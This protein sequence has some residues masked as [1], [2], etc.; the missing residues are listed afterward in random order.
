M[1]AFNFPQVIEIPRGEQSKSDSTQIDKAINYI[2]GLEK[3][4]FKEFVLRDLF[5]KGN[6]LKEDNYPSKASF[7]FKI[8]IHFYPDSFEVHR[9]LV[10]FFDQ[11]GAFEEAEKLL[12]VSISKNFEQ[13]SSFMLI[14]A[15]LY[16]ATGKP[17]LSVIEYEKVLRIDKGN[18]EACIFWPRT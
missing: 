8:L 3:E 17:D 12:K 13:R 1:T 2:S 14:L 15:G 6:D 16:S 5:I 10:V 4:S 7:A 18:E 11:E 9:D